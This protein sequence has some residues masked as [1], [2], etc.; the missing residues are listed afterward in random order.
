[1]GFRTK[2]WPIASVDLSPD[3]C[4]LLVTNGFGEMIVIDVATWTTVG[5]IQL[6]I[7]ERLIAA[8]FVDARRFVFCGTDAALHLWDG[9]GEPTRVASLHP[10]MS[11]AGCRGLAVDRATGRIAIVSFADPVG[12]KPEIHVLD[13]EGR[14]LARRWV[15]GPYRPA[16]SGEFFTSV[17]PLATGADARRFTTWA[18]T[19]LPSKLWPAGARFPGLGTGPET[20]AIGPGDILRIEEPTRPSIRELPRQH[21]IPRTGS[22]SPDGTTLAVFHQKS[23]DRGPQ[24]VALYA[25]P[26]LRELGVAPMLWAAD[27]AWTDDGGIVVATDGLDVHFLDGKTGAELG[28]GSTGQ[29]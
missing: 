6:G 25:W 18:G 5:A 23:G 20:L 28:V 14:E 21:G 7:A 2:G 17:D 15:P 19:D 11:P 27:Y 1:M 29:K 4:R 16:L 26:G 12:P 3:G 24:G 13:L 10:E 22:F 9:A 8:R